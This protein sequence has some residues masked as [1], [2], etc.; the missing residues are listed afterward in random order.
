M[1][2]LGRGLEYV[3]WLIGNIFIFGA[4][5]SADIFP[6][7]IAAFLGISVL[8]FVA[9]FIHELGHAWIAH[10]RGARVAKIA[11]LPFSYQPEKRRFAIEKRVP[12]TDIGGYVLYSFGKRG[13]TRK[14]AIAIA[15]AGPIANLLSALLVFV[16]LAAWP[17]S[18]GY[19]PDRTTQIA[20]VAVVP[21]DSE[22]LEDRPSP[23]TQF[24]PTQ[25]A[26][27]RMM[28][29]A[30]ARRNAEQW[31]EWTRGALGLFAAISL[32]LGLLN[33]VPTR[34]S[35]GASILRNLRSR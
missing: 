13:E 6:N 23:P 29:D 9:I 24:L 19:S 27:E 22:R 35:D 21:A 34:G 32:L 2:L 8:N 14:D 31:R 16:A 15:A 30:K 33:L 25:E 1:R 10:R 11:V 4:A 3:L 12:R 17:A 18:A 20:P 26:L 5:I 7:G 28:A